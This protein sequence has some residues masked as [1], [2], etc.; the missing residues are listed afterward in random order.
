MFTTDETLP[1]LPKKLVTVI[2]IVIVP[3]IKRVLEMVM[4]KKVVLWYL[5]K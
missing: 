2:V 1:V 5:F 3:G 4:G